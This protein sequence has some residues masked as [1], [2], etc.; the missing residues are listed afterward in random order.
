MSTG[1]RIFPMFTPSRG[2][3]G[4]QVSGL[5]PARNVG[6]NVIT[7]LE[8]LIARV[9]GQ[10]LGE[11]SGFNAK[12]E[13]FKKGHPNGPP[14]GSKKPATVQSEI[15]QY[16]RGPEVV[17]W[18]LEQANGLCECCSAPAP[19]IREDGSPFLEVH[20]VRRLADGGEDTIVNAIAICPNCHRKEHYA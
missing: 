18:V 20:H 7:A 4:S 2:V 15:T 19:F 5:K 12:V 11:L 6:T 3:S 16:V 17:A 9:E 8:A 10:T 14:S 1:C 13:K